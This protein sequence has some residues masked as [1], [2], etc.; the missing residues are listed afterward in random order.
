MESFDYIKGPFL[1]FSEM[2]TGDTDPVLAEI[3]NAS[4]SAEEQAL[5]NSM[6]SNDE[7]DTSMPISPSLQEFSDDE[8]DVHFEDLSSDLDVN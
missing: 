5:L 6:R 4:S 3:C 8:S 2:A 1:S 7:G